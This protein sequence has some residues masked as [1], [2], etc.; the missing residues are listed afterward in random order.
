MLVAAGDLGVDPAGAQLL[1]VEVL[2]TDGTRVIGTV[3]GR[4]EQP[5]PGP[6]LVTFSKIAP[7][8]Q[9]AAWVELIA[10]GATD[11]STNWRSVVVARS[12][13]K[14]ALKTLEL[15]GRGDTTDERRHLALEALEVAVDLYRRGL[16]EPIPL[17]ASLSCK[18]HDGT[19]SGDDW[20]PFGNH[21]DGTDEANRLAFGALGF[22]DLCALPAGLEDPPGSAPGRA[23]RFAH[24]LWDAIEASAEE[25]K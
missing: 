6:A 5:R 19:A 8:H 1:P 17:F 22:D 13:R 9:V 16:R 2:L 25:L 12:K 3:T 24:Y 14:G 23:A 20:E 15:V 18:L 11:P 7:K 10:L 21:G 4:C